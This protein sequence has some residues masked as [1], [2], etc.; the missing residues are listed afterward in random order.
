MLHPGSGSTRSIDKVSPPHPAVEKENRRIQ[1]IS[2]P[3]PARVEV[4]VDPK[5]TWN[6]ITRLSDVSAFGAGFTLK[7]PIRR[8]RLVLMTVPMPRQLRSFDFSEPQYKIWALVRRCVPVRRRAGDPEYSIGAAF[9]GKSPPPGY[10]D[11]PSMLYDI[12]HREEESTGFWHLVPADMMADETGAPIDQRKQTRLH[13]P[14]PLLLEKVDEAGNVLASEMTVT[15]N[16]SLG[17][18]A[19]FTTMDVAAGSF[20]RVTSERFNTTILSVVRA[21]R[22]G[23]DGI[24]RAHIEFI[25]RFFPLE[26]IE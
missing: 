2:L 25:D 24:K 22:V 23:Q 14:E 20:L 16:I 18:A 5:M 19:A 15:E 17:G 21:A 4:M 3:L 12:S 11:H 8:G 1:R 26:G 10:L 7:R 6:E 13:I 9:A